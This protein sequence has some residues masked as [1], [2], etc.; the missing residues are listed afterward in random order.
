[1]KQKYQ[2]KINKWINERINADLNTIDKKGKYTNIYIN[3]LKY[4]SL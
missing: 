1:M 4:I 3:D 2:L